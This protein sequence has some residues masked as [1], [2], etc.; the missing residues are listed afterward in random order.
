[1]LGMTA[2]TL[3]QDQQINYNTYYRYPVSIGVEYQN[4]TPFAN[5]GGNYNIFDLSAL[6][7]WPFLKTPVLVPMARLGI[8]RFDS[9][10]P[11]EP[12]KWDH[13]YYYLSL[14]MLYA[15]RFSRNF[16]IGAEASAGYAMGVFP[17]AV[18]EEGSLGTNNLLFE[19]GARIGLNPSYNFSIDV[20]PSLKYL[21]SLS[22]LK[23]FNGLIFGIGF[24]A[25]YRFGQDPDAP[26][27]AT[28][29][30]KFEG[31]LIPPA[32]SAMQSY[33]P[34][35]PLGSVTLT[36]TEKNPIS[37]IEVS[38]YQAG[39]MDS[40]TLSGSIEEL[41]AGERREVA[42]ITPADSALRN[43]ASFIRQTS[44]E[45]VIAFYCEAV[46]FG[47]QV[48]HALGEI[49]CLY[50]VDPTSPFTEV[51]GNSMVVDSISLPRDTLKRITG[52]CDDLT[53]L[54]DSVLETVG[55]ETGFI[56]V[57]GH[58]YAVFNTGEESRNFRKVHPGRD[59][60][61]EVEG[62]LWVP[63][64][65]TMIGRGDFNAAWRKGVEEWARYEGE[66]QRRRFYRTR[67]AQ[68]LY[69]PVGLKET[70]LGLQYGDPQ[71]IVRGFREDMGEIVEV[72]VEDYRV[73]AQ[74]GG[75]KEDWNR[76]GIVYAKF[77]RYDR[78]EE[79]FM[80]ALNMD[81]SYIDP[82]VN[83][84]TMAYLR[85]SYQNALSQFN[86]ALQTLQKKNE[87]QSDVGLRV[88][89]NISKTYYELKRYDKSKEFY[90]LA[91]GMDPKKTDKYAYL[92]RVGSEETRAAVTMDKTKDILFAGGEEPF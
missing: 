79:S 88:I 45:E 84:G 44:K 19:V 30:I 83:L 10:D 67:E 51:Q 68:E 76:L 6:V 90:D 55:I 37:D 9:Q 72:I 62:E 26:S 59:M 16:E 14:G 17:N 20:N 54:Y 63:V 21:Y 65:I 23:D 22:P 61:I 34:K 74:E 80:R 82:Q 4:L 85:G 43:Y 47:I 60:T 91:H 66:P 28:R 86:D 48:Y 18:P 42:F 24:G 87:V 11:V 38:F 27:A 15:N 78:A 50:Q 53:V 39:Y 49:G 64:E 29:S 75:K 89:L 3:A 40:P 56:T 5:Y 31:V 35:N 41:G 1:M 12:E 70:D 92:S 32:F 33:Y 8:M 7:R 77:N 69:R 13:R 73:A 71:E 36:N 58:I 2:Q 52:D 81:R 46:Q 57:P 25:H